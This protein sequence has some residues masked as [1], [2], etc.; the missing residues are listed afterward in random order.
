MG[1]IPIISSGISITTVHPKIFT[2]I[3]NGNYTY[4][5]F[6]STS[7]EALASLDPKNPGSGIYSASVNVADKDVLSGEEVKVRVTGLE[8]ETTYYVVMAGANYAHR[9]AG[10]SPI[11]T[12][13][14]ATNNPPVMDLSAASGTYRRY[15]LVDI[16]VVIEEPDGNAMTVRMET[17]GNAKL[18]EHYDGWH[19]V[20]N[21]QV[22]T[23]GSYSAT[24]VA[25]DEYN[26]STSGSISYTILENNPPLFNV[27][28]DPY[29][30]DGAG[31]RMLVDLSEHF[32]DEDGEPLNY[33]ASAV[34]EASSPIWRSC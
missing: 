21:C 30:L 6:A 24:V 19:F 8:F 11:K 26:V 16:P 18:E 29:R 32:F 13:R 3:S 28:F 27:P 15:Q 20:L 17:T 31:E 1:S 2:L 7:R 4:T 14:T 5:A 25:T 10:V 33:T 23:P 12:A 9:Y 22:S 34:T